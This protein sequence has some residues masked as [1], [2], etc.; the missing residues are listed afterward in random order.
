MESTLELAL[1]QLQ[2]AGCTEIHSIRLRVGLLSGAVP[3]AL[4][5][6]FDVLKAGTPAAK[7]TLE[8]ERTQGLFSCSECS[9]D[10]RLDSMQFQ[11]P[12]CGGLLTLREGGAELEL[13]QMEI[14]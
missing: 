9:N 1:E 12:R 13:A 2:K 6:A 10:T 5:F 14:S 8:I 11:C 3:E 4:E 7:A